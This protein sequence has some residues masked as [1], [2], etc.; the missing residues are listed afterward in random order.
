M[1]L[2]RKGEKLK[3]A[4]LFN[5]LKINEFYSYPHIVKIGKQYCYLSGKK[6]LEKGKGQSFLIIVSFN[7]PDNATE[8]YTQRWQIETCFK[9]MK[10]SGFNIE[11]THL[12]DKERV[13]KLI[14]L[15]MI[16]Y[17]WCYKVGIHLDEQVQK[18]KRKKHGRKAKSLVKYGL[19]YVSQ[20]L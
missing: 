15:V 7:E 3:V 17:I 5:S 2:P 1:F 9:T 8:Y 18:I 12:K 16:A 4:W 20:A 11:K 10:T 19:D 13:K 14:L 6:I